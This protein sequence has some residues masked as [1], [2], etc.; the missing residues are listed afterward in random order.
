MIILP[1]LYHVLFYIYD[2]FWHW[3]EQGEKVK[4]E[5]RERTR[6]DRM[7]PRSN[8]NPEE[9]TMLTKLKRTQKVLSGGLTVRSPFMIQK[10]LNCL[11]DSRILCEFMILESQNVKVKSCTYVVNVF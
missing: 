5:L 4:Y 2:Y 10:V 9:K 8:A 6:Q 1:R 3:N 7:A 11:G